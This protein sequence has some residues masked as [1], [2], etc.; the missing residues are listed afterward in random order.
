MRNQLNQNSHKLQATSH[1]QSRFF[2]FKSKSV[3]FT[4]A[5]ILFTFAFNLLSLNLSAQKQRFPKPEFE[6]GYEQPSPVTP[7]PRALAMEYFDVLILILVLA[8]ATYFALKSRSRQGILWLSIF[9]LVYFGFY[10]NGCICSIGAIQN[11]TLTF[12]DPAY[13]ISL[14]ALLFFI[15]PLVVTLFFGRTFC[16]GAC[17]LG[18][19]QDLVVV[20]PISL[21]K[22]LNKTLGLIPYLYLSLAVLFA[23]TGTDFII[24][25]YD[26][27]VGIFRMDAKFL[28]IV[29]GIAFLLMG[30]F[31]ARPY[32]R[33]LCPYGVLLSWMSRFSSRH[34]TITPSKCI[35]CKLCTHSC[36]FDAIDFPT[37]E[38]EVVKSG[39]GPKRFITYALVIPLWIA[40]GVFVG[41]K[42]HTFLSKAN[43]DVYLAELLIA[44]PELRNDPD[45]IDVQTFL[46]SGK[47]ME[48]LVSEA[49]A[50]REKFYIGS[51][52]AG[53]FMGLVIGMTLLNTVVFRK[54]Q[55][56]EPHKGNCFSCARCVD[57]CPVEK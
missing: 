19:I 12:F 18:A 46:A 37:N 26:P 40:L 29:L 27:F 11:V 53:G 22:W 48:Q 16:A 36:P 50:I 13:A 28:M 49:T 56:Y 2:G 7:E 52:I 38:K 51:M 5:F 10:R 31:V 54:R 17:P 45:N 43:Q 39:L 1:K 20:K 8:A 23:A 35:Q 14:T 57:Y 34:L 4:F 21:P 15:I 6:T 3:L 32:C 24:C 44:H 55:D 42:S 9:T 41:A 47:P 30:M 25:R 33:F